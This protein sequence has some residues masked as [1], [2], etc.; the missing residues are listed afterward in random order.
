VWGFHAHASGFFSFFFV[1]NLL[2]IPIFFK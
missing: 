2:F 1:N